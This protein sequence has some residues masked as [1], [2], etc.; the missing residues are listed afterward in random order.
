MAPET[1]EGKLN[2]L[3]KQ[4]EAEDKERKERKGAGALQPAAAGQPDAGGNAAADA[5]L[6]RQSQERLG[7]YL[8]EKLFPSYD[9]GAI[10]TFLRAV[11]PFVMTIEPE[12]S[13]GDICYSV[14]MKVDEGTARLV[15]SALGAG[16]LAG[17][18]IPQAREAS[19]PPSPEK[20]R[21]G[22]SGKRKTPAR[23]KEQRK[24]SLIGLAESIVPGSGAW[25]SLAEIIEDGYEVSDE[26][27]VVPHPYL[28]AMGMK[29]EH[30]PLAVAAMDYGIRYGSLSGWEDA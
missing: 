6:F 18:L 16:D 20:A 22:A 23:A 7:E 3:K 27:T 11:A 21:R 17:E 4:K 15:L 9:R 26:G 24:V 29:P 2:R 19:R 10:G 8:A 30:R 13:K 12:V 14:A 28:L 5:G 1:L 25:S